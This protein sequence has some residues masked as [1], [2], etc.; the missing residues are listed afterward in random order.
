MPEGFEVKI[1]QKQG[2]TLLS[3]LFNLSL[4]NPIRE[5]KMEKTRTAIGQHHILKLYR[6]YKYSRK[7]PRRYGKNSP[8]SSMGRQ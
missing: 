1:D 7:L 2:T 6:W 8:G 4:E 5:M 3:T